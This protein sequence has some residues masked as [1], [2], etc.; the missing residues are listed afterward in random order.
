MEL[1]NCFRVYIG[2]FYS[3]N[4][5]DSVF[6]IVWLF[7]VVLVFECFYYLFIRLVLGGLDGENVG[8]WRVCLKSFVFVFFLNSL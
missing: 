1:V 5:K 7:K 4:V 3:R 8:I 6:F 2:I